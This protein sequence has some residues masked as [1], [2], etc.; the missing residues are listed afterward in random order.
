MISAMEAKAIRSDWV[1]QVIDGR[2][3]LLQWLGGSARSGVFLTELAG[4]KA[5][6][7]AI[8]VTFAESDEDIEAHMAGWAATRALSHPHLMRLLHTGRCEMGD[9]ILL[10]SVAEYAEEVL[11]EILPERALTP[12]VARE[13]LKPVLDTLSYLHGKGLVH[14]HLRPSNIMVVD[15]KLKLSGDS[16]LVAG[17]T[18]KP[19]PVKSIHEA[20][21]RASGTVSPGGDLWSLGVTLVEALTQHPPA[22][23]KSVD[24]DPVVPKSIPQP[25]AGIARGCLRADPMGRC[26]LD[27]A[28]NWLASGQPPKEA[29]GKTEKKAP[30]KFPVPALVAAVLAMV[31]AVGVIAWRSHSSQPPA[32]AQPDAQQTAPAVTT[33]QPEAQQQPATALPEAQ[34]EE[35]APP[36]PPPASQSSNSSAAAGPSS[37]SAVAQQ[38]MPEVLPRAFASIHGKFEVRIRLTVDGAGNVSGATFDS[39]GPSKYFAGAAMKA[40]QQWKFKPG[41][42]GASILQFR[43][44]QAGAEVTTQAVH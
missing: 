40:A 18:G 10:Y 13:M 31:A 7:A 15:D 41:Q 22:W 20:P 42:A 44:T 33:R 26:T 24:E 3:T 37:D 11:S 1:G 19:V 30:S 38:V 34:T 25:Y 27:N 43:F 12:D 21:E 23:D 14:G 28:R 2:F 36:T 35:Q 29:A 39:E 9:G 4:P 16:L 17:E 8:K 5:R 6:K 32:P